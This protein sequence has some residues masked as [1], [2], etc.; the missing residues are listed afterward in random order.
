MITYKEYK[1]S[2]SLEK[3]IKHYYFLEHSDEIFQRITPDGCIELNFSFG[4][5][6]ERKDNN[7]NI[8]L[9]KES[10][11]VSRFSQHYFVKPLTTVK[12]IGICF[13]IG[14]PL[15]KNRSLRIFLCINL[16]NIDNSS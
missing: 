4:S 5:A 6:F 3:Y 1:P 14:I 8:D 10:Y 13:Y 2:V 16:N 7:G 12:L 9:Q 11:T 15:D